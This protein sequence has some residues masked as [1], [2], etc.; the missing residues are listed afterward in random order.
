VFKAFSPNPLDLLVINIYLLDVAALLQ[1]SYP[2]G[3]LPKDLSANVRENLRKSER[4]TIYKEICHF[5][6]PQYNY[7]GKTIDIRC[8]WG[9]PMGKARNCIHMPCPSF[10]EANRLLFNS[11]LQPGNIFF[12]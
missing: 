4:E 3:A 5:L 1:Y 2:A 6:N 10:W 12:F 8:L 7:I 11:T 9:K